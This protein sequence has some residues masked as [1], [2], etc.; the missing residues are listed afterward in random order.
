[1]AENF[2]YWLFTLALMAGFW[3]V[4]STEF[5]VNEHRRNTDLGIVQFTRA[6]PV[7]IGL[8]MLTRWLQGKAVFTDRDWPYPRNLY[9]IISLKRQKLGTGSN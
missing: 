7:V 8:V 1:M 6:I 5:R 3:F 4:Y 9:R 2:F